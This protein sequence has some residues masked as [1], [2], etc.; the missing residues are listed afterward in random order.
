MR[1][2]S[3]T[4]PPRFSGVRAGSASAARGAAARLRVT[5]IDKLKRHG[6]T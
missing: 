6:I 5:L 3:D 1:V 2:S 4:V